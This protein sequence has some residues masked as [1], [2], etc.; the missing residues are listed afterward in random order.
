MT[1]TSAAV[2][3]SNDAVLLCY[4]IRLD[5]DSSSSPV[6]CV[7]ARAADPYS[8]DAQVKTNVMYHPPTLPSISPS[9]PQPIQIRALSGVACLIRADHSLVCFHPMTRAVVTS[10]SSACPYNTTAT[11]QCGVGRVG[12]DGVGWIG[13]S[14]GGNGSAETASGFSSVVL[15]YDNNNQPA[16]LLLTYPH[17]FPTYYGQ[18]GDAAWNVS[19]AT[20][21]YHNRLCIAPTSFRNATEEFL[22]RSMR[23]VA[24]P[25]HNILRTTLD[26]V[27]GSSTTVCGLIA[28][29]RTIICWS[30]SG[31]ESISSLSP[32]SFFQFSALECSRADP[33]GTVRACGI[34]STPSLTGRML[35]WEA[36]TNT[37]HF[38][39]TYWAIYD[40]LQQADPHIFQQIV[41]QWRNDTSPV[42]ESACLAAM[43]EQ[44]ISS[45]VSYSTESFL[46]YH[47]SHISANIGMMNSAP[48][49]SISIDSA[50]WDDW[51][52]CAVSSV[53]MA[54]C[55]EAKA[56]SNVAPL[57]SPLTSIF[58]S[59][60]ILNGIHAIHHSSKVAQ[61]N[62]V[63]LHWAISVDMRTDGPALL[64]RPSLR[65]WSRELAP[66]STRLVDYLQPILS[67]ETF[68][69]LVTIVV[70]S[71]IYVVGVLPNRNN[72]SSLKCFSYCP[73]TILSFLSKQTVDLTKNDVRRI[74]VGY[75]TPDPQA[76]ILQDGLIIKQHN[77]QRNGNEWVYTSTSSAASVSS[78]LLNASIHVDRYMIYCI[79]SEFPAIS[80]DPALSLPGASSWR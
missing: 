50:S 19:T 79:D 40:L 47:S 23:P 6:R 53:P 30:T 9:S 31:V 59:S 75:K 5:A 4:I 21:H 25:L 14:Y 22:I 73:S 17:R 39:Q 13:S 43:A 33:L 72:Q 20:I 2:Y 36:T 55:F 18:L 65:V 42:G 51:Y 80:I 27:C 10:L 58:Q 41:Q 68:D 61:V 26:A 77:S 8:D 24:L 11:Y 64:N 74:L 7:S 38:L 66:T 15:I 44:S 67:A 45:F 37:L 3:E 69:S 35:C 70:N 48:A 54:F 29:D 62:P 28:A 71:V 32:P 78:R 57:I 16:L 49:V 60:V 63:D 56:I 76:A 34:L 52:L 46:S 1:L 12:A